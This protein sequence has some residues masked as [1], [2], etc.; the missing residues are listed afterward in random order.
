MD[1]TKFNRRHFLT[2]LSLS[3]GYLMFRNPL[4]SFAGTGMSADPFQTIQLGNTGLKTSLIGMGTGVHGIRRNSN[5][6]RQDWNHALSVVGHAYESGIRMFDSADNYGTHPL[7]A[8]AFKQIM[9]REE[10]TLISKIW[11]RPGGLPEDARPD[12]DKVVD[13]FLSELQSDYIDLLQI[14]CMVDENWTE[15]Y[16]KQMDIISDLKAKGKVRA[17]GVSVHTLE[18]MKTALASD[19]VEVVHCRINPYG[20]AMDKPDPQE[21][22]SVIHDLH[23]SGKG[24]IGMKVVGD[25]KYSDDSEK[26]DHTIRFVMGLGSVDMIIPGFESADQIDNYAGRVKKVLI[27]MKEGQPGNGV[28]V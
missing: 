22:V 24:V 19:W 7:M 3:T 21:V 2:A 18:A 16:A 15:I 14:H 17:H 13:R 6:A 25:G 20:I 23:N 8:E 4:S 5:L 12:A 1:T 28:L 11:L 10:I 9:P 26:I 27:A